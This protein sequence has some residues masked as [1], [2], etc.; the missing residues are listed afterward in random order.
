MLALAITALTFV[1]ALGGCEARTIHGMV[2]N[3]QGEALPGVTVVVRDTSYEAQTNVLGEYR[4][5]YKPGNVVLEFY[6]TGFTPGRLE[7]EVKSGR[8]V[9]ATPISLW[10][11]PIHKGV[12]LYDDTKH[13]YSD[14][15]PIEPEQFESKSSGTVYGTIRW[16]AVTTTD[17][18]PIILCYKMPEDGMQF[19]RI[20][21]IELEVT[22]PRG[23][24]QT[25]ELWARVGDTPA[26]LVPVD[27]PEGVLQ[28][29]RLPEPLTPGTYA[30]HWGALDGKNEFDESRM[31]VFSVVEPLP[32][33]AP[34][35]EN[36]ESGETSESGAPGKKE[37]APAAPAELEVN[38]PD[39]A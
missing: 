32:P 8:R 17:A 35:E 38:V 20:D 7:L 3:I 21:L 27:D 39:E 6:K 14:T 25:L 33:P 5:G 36:V 28:Q 9:V 31:F 15:R 19:C 23:R 24:S 30:V 2:Y 11:L 4:I 37:T 1:L 18:Q 10:R 13:E 26:G 34:G 16:A 12:Y 29:V 22:D